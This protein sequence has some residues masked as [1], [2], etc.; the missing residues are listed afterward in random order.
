MFFEREQPDQGAEFARGRVGDVEREFEFHLRLDP[1]GGGAI[2]V[3]S[4]TGICRG[5][6]RETRV[7]M[8]R[9]DLRP[10][11]AVPSQRPACSSVRA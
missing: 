9:V 11:D 3:A 2:L 10:A 7:S 1:S 4:L 5:L 8:M 6:N